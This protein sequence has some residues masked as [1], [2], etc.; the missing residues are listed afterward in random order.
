MT[1]LAQREQNA[2]RRSCA[3]RKQL[4]GFLDLPAVFLDQLFSLPYH[5]A[6]LAAYCRHYGAYGVVCD[7]RPARG[8]AYQ[9]KSPRGMFF[10]KI[11]LDMNAV[12]EDDMYHVVLEDRVHYDSARA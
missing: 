4:D 9:R 2:R 8:H 6:R 10:G 7:Q 12:F 3:P 5:H 1:V 11:D